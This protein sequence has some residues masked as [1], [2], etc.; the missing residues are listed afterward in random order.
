MS[1][2]RFAA[3]S[4]IVLGLT[5]C[6]G[7]GSGN[8]LGNPNVECNPGTQVQLANPAPGQSGV[9]PN[10]GSVTIV[11]N[12]SNNALYSAYQQW[13]VLLVDTFTRQTIQGGQLAL[14]PDPSGPHPYGSDFYYQASIPQLQPGQNWN[15]E[16]VQ[17]QSFASCSPFPTN[18]FST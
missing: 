7:G 2:V 6:G 10:V 17:S 11:A 16:L 8:L 13:N 15:V 4:C 3:L 18:A 14:V 12:G 9:N 5:A 1:Y